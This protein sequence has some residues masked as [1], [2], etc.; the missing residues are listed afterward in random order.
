VSDRVFILGAGRAGRGLAR[1]LRASGVDIVGLHGTR[2]DDAGGVTAGTMPRAVSSATVVLVA[3]RDAQL[4]A[5]IREVARAPLSGSAVV[6]HAS[7]GAEPRALEGLRSAGRAA[8]TFHPLV[9]LADPDRA[10][11]VLNGAWIGIDGDAPALEASRRL[12]SRLSAHTVLIPQGAKAR[13]HA[14]AVFAANFPTVLAAIAH[15]L[16]RDAGIPDADGWDAVLHLMVA[17]VG[18]IHANR[19][20][21]A[22]TGPIVRGDVDTVDHHLEALAGDR[23][24]TD[25]Y[26]AISRAALALAREA[27]TDAEM[28]ARISEILKENKTTAV[29]Q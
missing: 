7:G 3:V 16:L 1:A 17:A 14:A 12:A 13:Y 22:L 18:N 5:A 8:G 28:L 6:L 2:A 4:D 26:R 29:N 24:A 15:R 10:S 21:E 20:A 27:G 11:E 23:E 9:P 19:P 25:I